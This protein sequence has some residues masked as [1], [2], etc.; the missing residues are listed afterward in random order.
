MLTLYHSTYSRST[1]V[2]AL[3]H[4]MDALDWVEVRP[5]SIHR[6]DGTGGRD[7]ANPHPDGK[8]PYLI[9][10]GV[11]VWETGAIMVYL[12][13]MFPESG[14]GF[15]QGHPRRGEYLSWM[16]WY[17]SVLEPVLIQKA[18][19]VD[20]P[21]LRG[22]I[23]GVEEATARLAGALKR[24]PWIMGDRYTAVDLLLAS[25][26]LWLKDA[27]PDVPALRDWVARAAAQ[28]CYE[29]ARRYDGGLL[30]A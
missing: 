9:H 25:P 18:A 11:E 7:A 21:Y 14:M 29:A 15:P 17:G 28:P 10:D 26:Y 5:V 20:H 16:V 6:S 23:R 13:D 4:A 2:M 19:G 3:L 8:V 1:R 22:A 24:G 30:A 12:T 27:T